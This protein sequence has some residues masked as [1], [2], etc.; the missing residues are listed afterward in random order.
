MIYIIGQRER[1]CV[2]VCET[3]KARQ[4]LDSAEARASPPALAVSPSFF[5]PV[6]RPSL[7][8]PSLLVFVDAGDALSRPEEMSLRLEHAFY[9]C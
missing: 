2:C 9:F 4:R 1:E 7:A 8:T 6:E 5:S 3:A